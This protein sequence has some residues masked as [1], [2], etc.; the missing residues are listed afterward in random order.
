MTHMG[1]LIAAY[2]AVWIIISYYLVS[3]YLKNKRLRAEL[4]LLEERIDR[5]EKHG[6]P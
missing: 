4:E 6:S 5:L 3:L 1:Y 2:T